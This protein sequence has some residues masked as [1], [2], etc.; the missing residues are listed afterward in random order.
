VLN[1][2]IYF[3]KV[4]KM[5]KVLLSVAVLLLSS[6]IITQNQFI[7]KPETVKINEGFLQLSHD[8]GIQSLDS[9]S[10]ADYLKNQLKKIL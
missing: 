2:Y 3:I 7:P 1:K 9:H 8:F 6:Q 5:K 10:E 4:F